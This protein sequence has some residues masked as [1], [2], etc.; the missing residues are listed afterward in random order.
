VKKQRGKWRD[1]A[2]AQNY[3]QGGVRIQVRDRAGKVFIKRAGQV[4]W[5]SVA[6]WRFA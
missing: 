6:Q 1:P 3:T 5:P 2:E 4:D